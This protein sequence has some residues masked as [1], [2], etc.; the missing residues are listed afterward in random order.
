LV[1]LL[2]G[3]IVDCQLWQADKDYP[4]SEIAK[5]LIFYRILEARLSGNELGMLV[6]H[7]LFWSIA[8]NKGVQEFLKDRPTAEDAEDL[9]LRGMRRAE[10]QVAK[11]I[12]RSS[13]LTTMLKTG[14]KIYATD[15][16]LRERIE[17]LASRYGVG[18]ARIPF[19]EGVWEEICIQLG[20]DSADLVTFE[21]LRSILKLDLVFTDAGDGDAKLIAQ[22]LTGLTGLD[23]VG[24]AITDEGL[25]AVAESL[26]GLTWLDLGGT[27]ITDEGLRAVAKKLTGLTW[28]DVVGTAITDEGLRAVAQNLTG[29]TRFCLGGEAITDEGLRAVAKI[30]TGLSWLGVVGTAITDEGLRAVAENLTGLTDLYLGGTAIT[31]EGLRAV[32]EN[33]T[34]LT[35]L[36]L[37]GTAITDEGLRAVAENLTGLTDLYLGGTA[38]TDEAVTEIRVMRPNLRVRR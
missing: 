21:Q 27:A 14:A 23:V 26:T 30:L 31:D 16:R 35:T 9:D 24:T 2:N 20:V 18:E 33:L 4:L 15:R 11:V 17:S 22:Y 10:R 12:G 28:L 32:A 3:F 37:N 8:L 1:R 34:G 7:D 29:L 19:S 13:E 6:D 36:L 25:R 5:A 38:I